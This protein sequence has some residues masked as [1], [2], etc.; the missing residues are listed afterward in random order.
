[1]RAVA[2]ATWHWP[3]QYGNLLRWSAIDRRPT[4]NPADPSGRKI[5]HF[6]LQTVRHQADDSFPGGGRSQFV[7]A[8]DGLK[9]HVRVYGAAARAKG[10][11]LPVICLPGLA[12]TAADFDAVALALSTAPECPRRVFALDYRGR[13]RSDYDRR[14]ANYNLQVELADV[15][16]VLTALEIPRAAFIGTSRGGI[17]SMLLAAARPTAIAGCVLNDIGPVIELKG[18]MR[19][20][21]YVGKLPR[22]ASIH[23]A[24]D[25]LRRMFASQFPKW[26]DDDWVVFARLTFKETGSRVVPAYDVKLATTLK[27]VR[28]DRPL[29]PLWNAFDALA[30]RPILVIRGGNSDILSAA[31]VATMRQRH[32]GLDV[33]EVPDEGHAPRLSDA[34]TLER[35]ATFVVKC[36][37]ANGE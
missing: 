10:N 7:T 35:I 14:P 15:L 17:L 29:A 27:G 24:A 6:M 9:L 13:G 2:P 32:R 11:A 20:K 25:I 5:P 37:E 12:R 26:T 23:E 16:T 36:D 21:S 30:G 33:L 3:R 28:P 8:Q 31:T 1:M 34:A 19:I 18:L 4:P 22:P